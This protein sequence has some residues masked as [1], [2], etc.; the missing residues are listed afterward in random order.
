MHGCPSE[1]PSLKAASFLIEFSLLWAD[2]ASPI[3]V[4]KLYCSMLNDR[5]VHSL[6]TVA[7]LLFQR[8]G[9]MNVSSLQKKDNGRWL[10][11]Q[12]LKKTIKADFGAFIQKLELLPL[13]QPAHPK[14]PHPLT[15]LNF[16]VSD[17]F[18]IEG[19]VTGFGDPDWVRTHEASSWTSPVVLT[20]VKGGATCVG[21]T[22]VDELAYSI[23]GEN[24]YYSTPTNPAEPACVPGGSSSGAAVAIAANSVDFSLGLFAK[25]PNILHR[26]GLV[27]MQ[28]PFL[29]KCNPRKILL[30]D[31]CFQLLKI[32][33]DRVLQV[34]TNS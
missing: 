34:V 17:V 3:F 2:K 25:D 6:F 4:T 28:L 21:K 24:K 27:L 13:P 32:P 14:A 1:P 19:Y 18:D 11:A 7:S 23:H 8:L 15:G 30:A 16:A 12:R 29:D 33:V 31:D 10:K 22:V 26:V 5:L 9:L 20:L